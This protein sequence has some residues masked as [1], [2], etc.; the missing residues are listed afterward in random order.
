MNTSN[1]L[2]TT[3]TSKGQVTIPAAIREHLGISPKDSVLFEV[4]EDGSVRVVPAPSQLKALFA[5]IQPVEVNQDDK[6]KRRDFEEE[7]AESV[8]RRDT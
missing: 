8:L 5:S 6:A 2:P 4:V 7:V 3:V 1:T